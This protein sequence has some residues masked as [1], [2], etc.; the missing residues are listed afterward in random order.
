[1]AK[2]TT[3]LNKQMGLINIPQIF[4]D[5]LQLDIATTGH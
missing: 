4:K 1:M 5:Y 3:T 2:I